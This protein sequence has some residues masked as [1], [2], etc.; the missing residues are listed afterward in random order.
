[1]CELQAL[2]EE[3]EATS[4][5]AQVA[6]NDLVTAFEELVDPDTA[7]AREGKEA[8]LYAT[9]LNGAERLSKG[10]KAHSNLMEKIEA[11]DGV[12]VID[13]GLMPVSHAVH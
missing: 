5:A 8:E 10:R 6:I 3:A 13:G 2:S 1:M 12:E 9:L 11:M 7:E 4:Q